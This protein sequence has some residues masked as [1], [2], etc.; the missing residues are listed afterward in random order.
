[1][2]ELSQQRPSNPASQGRY[3]LSPDVVFMPLAD[4]TAQ[5]IDLDG[6][7]YGLSETA[8]LML[9]NTLATDER[10]ALQQIAAHYNADLDR[11]HADLAELLRTLRAKGLIRCTD[12]RVPAVGL[13]TA[14]AVAISYPVFK[15]V[16]P[17][18]NQRLRVFVL[19]ALAR[20]C[21]ALFG[22]ARTVAAWHKCLRCFP[23]LAAD[24]PRQQVIDTIDD[25]VGRSADKLPSISC[26]ERA[27]CC[28]Y[29]L[30]S[31]GVPAKLVM[32]VRFLPF[33]R[34]VGVKLM[35]EP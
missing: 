24:S 23:V 8:A 12:D 4:G 2:A 29:M 25:A 16:T 3:L 19:L 27:L 10:G 34:I 31:A 14:M 30:R 17:I 9:K 5:L 35:H 18:H 33:R 1:M 15:I 7:F 20:L 22:W 32:G 21:F 26:K 13:R 6:S 28:W 11:V